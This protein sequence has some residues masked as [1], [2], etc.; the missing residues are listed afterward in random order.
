V[1]TSS[2][3]GPRFWTGV[4]VTILCLLTGCSIHPVGTAMVGEKSTPRGA[5]TP[6]IGLNHDEQDDIDNG[7]QNGDGQ[8]TDNVTPGIPC[9]SKYHPSYSRNL[10]MVVEGRFDN[11][12]RYPVVLDTGASVAFFVND[13]HIIENKRAIYPPATDGSNLTDVGVC[14]LPKL[15]IGGVTLADWPCFYRRQLSE[16]KLFGLPAAKDKV[17]IAGLPALRKFKYIMFDSIREEVEFSLQKVFEPD[18]SGLWAR[19][20]FTIEEGLGGNAYLFVKI[21]IAGEEAELQLDTGS[22]RGL[23]ISEDLWERIRKEIPQAKLKKGED[24]YP[25]IGQ[26]ACRR[27]VVPKL[28]VGDRMVKDAMISVFPNDSPLLDEGRGLLGM[29]YFRDTVMVLDFERNL[30]WVNNSKTDD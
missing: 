11:G 23:A 1:Q 5:D 26:L 24:L 3:I 28:E 14:H 12:K 30:M 18:G 8:I 2:Q 4:L 21:P 10:W 19:Y 16:F 25:Y 13:T 17:I 20:S 29:Q 22:G 7:N 27:G 6:L 15:Y 9:R